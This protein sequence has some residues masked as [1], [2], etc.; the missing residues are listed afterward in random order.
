MASM[1]KGKRDSGPP[2]P[3]VVLLSFRGREVLLSNGKFF[4]GRS[5][6]CHIVI[7]DA[8][9]S[10]QHA[11]LDVYGASVGI[12]DLDSANGV[13]INGVQVLEGPHALRNGD[14]I[15]IARENLRLQIKE[16]TPAEL[17]DLR[18]KAPDTLSGTDS[19]PPQRESRRESF[20]VPT[21]FSDEVELIFKVAEK[22]LEAGNPENAEE[23]VREHLRNLL[24]DAGTDHRAPPASYGLATNFALRLA[25]ETGNGDWFDYVIDMLRVRD[26]ACSDQLADRLWALMQRVD[27]VD[28]DRLEAYATS[29]RTGSP[30]MES[31]RAAQRMEELKRAALRRQWTGK[32][33]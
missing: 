13:R 26:T 21:R 7:D 14:V 12:T 17:E 28:V 19:V 4:I 25:W 1:T 8:R 23:M 31:L 3:M 32:P 15:E 5:P 27:R 22:G 24:H 9:V 18:G 11:R 33:R 20:S 29:L 2:G 6:G 10:R 16:A 30:S